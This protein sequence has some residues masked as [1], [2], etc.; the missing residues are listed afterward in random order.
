MTVAPESAINCTEAVPFWLIA[1]LFLFWNMHGS[2]AVAFT[3]DPAAK[4]PEAIAPEAMAPDA[5]APDAMAPEATE[6]EAAVIALCVANVPAFVTA[7]PSA[8]TATN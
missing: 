2:A 1:K 6:P 7:N 4:A 8:P 3:N 5:T